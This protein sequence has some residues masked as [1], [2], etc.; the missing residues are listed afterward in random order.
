MKANNPHQIKKIFVRLSCILASAF[1]L[2]SFSCSF[3]YGGSN[4]SGPTGLIQAPSAYP[5]CSI[6]YYRL[7]GATTYLANYAFFNKALEV[8]YVYNK[9]K[10]SSSLNLKLPLITEN[11]M[12]PQVAVGAFN[13]RSTAV[14]QTNY[15]VVSKSV[16][17]IGLRLHVGYENSGNL[18]DAAGLLNYGTIQDAV[19]DYKN[20]SGKTFLGCEFTVL[21]MVSIMGEKHR[22]MLNG[23]IRFKPLPMLNIDYDIL[24]IK[25]ER[26]LSNKR[27]LNM[28][29]SV[30]F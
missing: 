8:G 3:V 21:P 15:L 6:G 14:D 7:D 27:V 11:G 26:R 29:F 10:G 23:G 19:D 2:L 13:Y 24:D 9:Q 30:D 12:L 18:K 20:E 17:S 25:N 5:G 22:N 4:L 1:I 16:D 28:N